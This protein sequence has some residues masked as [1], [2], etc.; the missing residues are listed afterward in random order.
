[1]FLNVI[2]HFRLDLNANCCL[3][4]STS[5]IVPKYCSYQFF[6]HLVYKCRYK[7]VNTVKNE[8]A[9]LQLQNTFIS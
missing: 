5:T 1:M 9:N 8:N 6:I 3:V 4:N 2:L 7:N